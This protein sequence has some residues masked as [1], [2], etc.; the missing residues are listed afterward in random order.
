MSRPLIVAFD[1]DDTLWHNEGAF[2]EVEQTFSRLVEPWA[3][4][5]AAQRA[6]IAHERTRVGVY[7]YGVKSFAL[8][9]IAT[10]CELSNDEI[11][12]SDLRRFVEIADELLAL[13][14]DMIDGAHDVMEAV[15]AVFPTM[16]IT[17]GDLHHQLRRIADAD[18]ARFC[19]DI[20]VVAEKDTATYHRM[21]TRHRIEASRFVMVGNSVVSDVAPVVELGGRAIHVPYH[22][23]WALET[24]DGAPPPADRWTA[25]DSI[26]EV[27][28]VLETMAADLASSAT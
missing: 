19:F 5:E 4:A 24:H 7:G 23:T 3:D 11:P 13:P 17:K 21:F 6:L 16:I 18:V 9:M 2:A 10:A 25:V 1:A 22:T 26:R 8:S 15:S 27:P 12:A 20:E 28:G 14:T